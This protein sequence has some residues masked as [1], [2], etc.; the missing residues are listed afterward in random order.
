[1]HYDIKLDYAFKFLDRSSPRTAMSQVEANG[2][3]DGRG[4]PSLQ[5]GH[6]GTHEKKRER[7]PLR[8]WRHLSAI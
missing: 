2:D 3:D 1:M 5:K 4:G 8:R 7:P 6:R